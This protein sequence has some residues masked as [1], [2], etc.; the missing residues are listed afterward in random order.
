MASKI[1]FQILFVGAFILMGAVVSLPILFSRGL[2][3]RLQQTLRTRLTTII[4][5][6]LIAFLIGFAIHARV[7]ADS[8]Y[9]YSSILTRGE[10]SAPSPGLGASQEAPEATE[11]AVFELWVRLIVPPPLRQA[12]Y[13]RDTSVCDAADAVIAVTQEFDWGWGVYLRF[14]RMGLVTGLT[15]AGLVWFYTRPRATSE[16][17]DEAE[18]EG[19][20]GGS[21]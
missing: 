3:A 15:S 13:T 9:D 17:E 4:V 7:L 8:R 5:Y 18:A 12:C 16:S 2:R 14:V 6:G 10:E 1:I 19:Q 20:S 11:A 21:S